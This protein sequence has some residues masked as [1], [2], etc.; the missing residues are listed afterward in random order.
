MKKSYKLH[1]MTNA[2]E[3]RTWIKIKTRCY[4]VK[5][6]KYHSYGGRGISI[7]DEW[8]K[9][10]MSFYDYIGPKPTPLHSIDRIDSDG[11]YEPGNVRWA[12]NH[13]QN[14]N[15]SRNIT[16]LYK[17]KTYTLAQLAKEIDRPYS[18]VVYH[19]RQGKLP[20]EIAALKPVGRGD[21]EVIREYPDGTIELYESIRQA[22]KLTGVAQSTIRRQLSQMYYGQCWRVYMDDTERTVQGQKNFVVL[23]NKWLSLSELAREIGTEVWKVH[24]AWKN[25]KQSAVDIIKHIFP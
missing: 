8:V 2:P 7:H 3:Y 4:D 10:F 11:N 1:G 6:E 25:G 24:E 23:D 5:H 15:T 16:A 21:V 12:D 19:I 17:G 22:S 20:N 14:N 9:D 18:F 13:T